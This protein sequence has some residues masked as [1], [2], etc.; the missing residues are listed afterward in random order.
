MLTPDGRF[1]ADFAYPHANLLIEAHSMQFH[2]R[3]RNDRD[4]RRH[5]V[6]VAAGYDIVYV[7]SDMIDDPSSFIPHVWS[8]LQR[9]AESAAG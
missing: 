2:G 7:T 6:L 9:A 8:A 5:I 3:S 1:R 4:M